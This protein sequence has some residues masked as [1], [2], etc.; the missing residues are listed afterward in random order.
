MSYRHPFPWANVLFTCGILA[1]V[2]AALVYACTT[3]PEPSPWWS[4]L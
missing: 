4:G 1:L 2:V 3:T